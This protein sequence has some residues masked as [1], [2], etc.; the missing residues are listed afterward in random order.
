MLAFRAHHFLY[1]MCETYFIWMG[2]IA[3]MGMHGVL[4]GLGARN[5]M[6]YKIYLIK[7]GLNMYRVCGR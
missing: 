1:I 2:E 3:W 7:H 6:A 4:S 5:T